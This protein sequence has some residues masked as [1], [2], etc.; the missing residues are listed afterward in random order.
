M[1]KYKY[2]KYTNLQK[3]VIYNILGLK[4][5]CEALL[6]IMNNEE[7]GF[8]LQLQSMSKTYVK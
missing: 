1:Y 5:A 6:E 7:R 4:I 3:Y 2:S 8:V